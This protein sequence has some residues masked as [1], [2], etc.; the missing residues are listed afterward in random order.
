LVKPGDRA[1]PTVVSA[2]SVR[3]IRCARRTPTWA[4][5]P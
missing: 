2:R 1:R 3:A 5:R 4:T